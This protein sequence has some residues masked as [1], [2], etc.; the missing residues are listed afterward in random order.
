MGIFIRYTPLIAFLLYDFSYFSFKIER[1]TMKLIKMFLTITAKG[2]LAYTTTQAQTVTGKM[3]SMRLVTY[4]R[5]E[6]QS[7]T[8]TWLY[9]DYQ[10][11]DYQT[12]VDAGYSIAF[13]DSSSGSYYSQEELNEL[14][15]N[16]YTIVSSS[17]PV[18]NFV[19]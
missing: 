6:T 11:D 13:V 7:D 17:K 18:D 3:G 1:K 12:L 14:D 5:N 10:A 8:S 4:N 2:A 19:S 16:D 15:S 9:T